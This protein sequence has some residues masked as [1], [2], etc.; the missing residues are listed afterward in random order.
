MI[1]IG[2]NTY[3]Q[4]SVEDIINEL[5]K[6][7]PQMFYKSVDTPRNYMI[8][9]PFHKEG[10]EKKP[11]MGIH[12]QSGVCHCFSCEWTGSL[13]EM[14]SNLFG[15]NDFGN[16]GARWLI[17]NFN[18]LSIEERGE[19]ELDL[20]R[21]RSNNSINNRNNTEYVTEEEL[22]KYRYYHPYWRK[23]KITDDWLFDLFDL[24]YDKE[25]DCI[26][27]PNRDINGNCVFVARRNV[28]TKYFNYPQ[29]VEKPVYGLY[30]ISKYALEMG[31]QQ[32]KQYYDYVFYPI[33]AYPNDVI[34]CESMIDA[35]TCWQY[36]K[37]A[38][39]L[40]GLGTASQIKALRSAPYRHYILATD[41]DEA[42]I[43]ARNHLAK[44]LSNKIITYYKWDINKAKDIND[45]SK[46]MFDSLQ[47]F[48]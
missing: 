33:R 14:V 8:C 6:Q 28:N 26:T 18:S 31:I 48:M 43:K 27:M 39:A 12:K 10:M 19:L 32:N 16:Y 17:R 37:Y 7:F 29:G 25:T 13:S 45:M 40:N 34:I 15:Y 2:P 35:L 38:V 41:M 11:S 5:K 4:S 44:Q 22:D 9:C 1:E 42:G 46:E 24:G 30:E 3:I 23:R 36:G 47:E 21:N 20:E